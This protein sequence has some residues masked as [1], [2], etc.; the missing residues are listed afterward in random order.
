MRIDTTI[1]Y[2]FLFSLLY[3]MSVLSFVDVGREFLLN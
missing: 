2:N 3:K 1:R